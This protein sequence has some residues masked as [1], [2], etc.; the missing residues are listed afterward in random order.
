MTLAELRDHYARVRARLY[1]GP[2][3]VNVI[4]EIVPEPV[5]SDPP[6]ARDGPRNMR[7]IADLVC[8][9]YG[10]TLGDIRGQSRRTDIVAARQ[11]L[12]YWIHRAGRYSS[13]QIGRFVNNDHTTVLHGIKAHA[14]RRAKR[15]RGKSNA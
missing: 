8:R 12:M 2:V 5:V 14:K 10:V 6:P 9:Y 15:N 4:R 13:P 3:R 7:Q 1:G 11:C